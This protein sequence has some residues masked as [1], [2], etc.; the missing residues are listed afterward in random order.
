M[1]GNLYK[2]HI[3]LKGYTFTKVG[4]RSTYLKC[5]SLQLSRFV[6][7]N[8][9]NANKSQADKNSYKNKIILLHASHKFLSLVALLKWKNQ[10]LCFV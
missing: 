5:A 10:K 6:I 8:Y 2:S 4:V 9:L 3:L 1:Q 7:F